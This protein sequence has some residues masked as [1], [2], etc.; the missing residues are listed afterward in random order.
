[1]HTVPDE[2]GAG[3]DGAGKHGIH[4]QLSAVP[5]GE[6]IAQ[7]VSGSCAVFVNLQADREAGL[8][9]GNS[10]CI[11]LGSIRIA[12]RIVSDNCLGG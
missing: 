6:P 9:Y 11:A 8:N 4:G 12:I 10:D 1:M 2:Q 7:P 5:D 3:R